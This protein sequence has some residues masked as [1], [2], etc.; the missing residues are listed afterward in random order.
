M[1]ISNISVKIQDKKNAKFTNNINSSRYSE[2]PDFSSYGYIIERELGCNIASGRVTYQAIDLETRQR[3]V[4][5]HF[6]FLRVTNWSG[7]EAYEREIKVL[8]Q[9]DISGIPRYI[10]DFETSTG[11]CLV[12]EYKAAPSLAVRCNFTPQQ[13]QVI[14][15]AILEI[16][17]Y[18]QQQNPPMIHRDIKPENILV[19]SS[20]QIKVYLVDFGFARLSGRDF[21]ASSTVKGTLGFMPLEQIFN[22][23][24]SEASDLYSLGVTIICLLTRTK[25]TEISNLIDE[26]FRIDVKKLKLKLNREFIRWLE[27]MV[28]P[29]AE[30]RYLNAAEALKALKLIELSNNSSSFGSTVHSKIMTPAFGLAAVSAVALAQT[31]KVTDWLKYS[32]KRLLETSSPAQLLTT[33]ECQNC[34]AENSNQENADLSRAELQGAILKDFNFDRADLRLAYLRGADLEGASLV[35]ANLRG[36]DLRKAN[37]KNANLEAANLTDADLE[38]ANLEGV[39]LTNANPQGAKLWAVNLRDANLQGADLARSRL[40]D[41]N[42]GRAN[43]KNTN[44]IDA[45]LNGVNLTGA[46]LKG[47]YVR[48]TNFRR[49]IMPNGRVFQRRARV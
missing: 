10:N 28:A 48:G 12:T 41:A 17:V 6:Q 24:L 13:I 29:N 1:H 18:L 15:I 37:L 2:Y 34:S 40:W 46:N 26:S 42:L 33:K 49:A 43:L 5:K 4:I 25:S 31:T 8:K 16:L 23:Q 11:F 14:A 44:L 21:A 36:A 22:C 7:Y 3:V 19:D 45:S 39:N 27:K 38:E 30:K 20:E 32:S 47:A 9:L 35:S